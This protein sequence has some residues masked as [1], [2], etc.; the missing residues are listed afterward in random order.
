MA[1]K[2]SKKKANKNQSKM[3]EDKPRQRSTE[4]VPK[5]PTGPIQKAKVYGGLDID[6]LVEKFVALCVKHGADHILMKSW[7]G[8]GLI[9]LDSRDI[10]SVV[11]F[12]RDIQELCKNYSVKVSIQGGINFAGDFEDSQDS[13]I[14]LQFVVPC[15]VDTSKVCGRLKV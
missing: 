15:P 2:A 12:L 5:V 4:V 9:T 6:E 3:F 10:E 14:C 1:K 13:S 11:A 7:N 8:A